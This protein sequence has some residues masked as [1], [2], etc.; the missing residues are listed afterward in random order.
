MLESVHPLS[1]VPFID[2][3]P[4][5]SSRQTRRPFDLNLTDA[6]KEQIKQIETS[7]AESTKALHEQLFKA[8]GGPFAGL[9]DG[10]FDESAVRAEFRRS[11]GDGVNL[12]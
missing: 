5:R 9:G 4:P 12:N 7:F 11:S 3:G 2:E 6:Q 8:G 1:K 10:T